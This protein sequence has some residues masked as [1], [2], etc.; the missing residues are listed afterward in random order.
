MSRAVSRPSWPRC[1]THGEPGARVGLAWP[2]LWGI[3]PC[4]REGQGHGLAQLTTY[5][6]RRKPMATPEQLGE[7]IF[8]ANPYTKQQAPATMNPC[9]EETEK[10]YKS[11]EWDFKTASYRVNL[12]LRIPYYFTDEYGQTVKDYLLIGFEGSGGV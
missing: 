6:R 1:K 4:L 12:A 3:T 8:K 5:Q 9:L 11:V 7:Y 2:S 10:Y